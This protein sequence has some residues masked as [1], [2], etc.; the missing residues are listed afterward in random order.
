M[1][2]AV[3][4]CCLHQHALIGAAT[5]RGAVATCDVIGGRV[6]ITVHH[7]E[8][9]WIRRAVL[10]KELEVGKHDDVDAREAGKDEIGRASW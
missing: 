2:R 1:E 5:A 7:R 8:S 6:G 4:C 10:E 3:V 9:V